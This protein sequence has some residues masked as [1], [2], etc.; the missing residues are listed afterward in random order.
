M[1]HSNDP[2][3]LSLSA[4]WERADVAREGDETALVVRVQASTIATSTSARAPLD[5]AF[6]LDRSGS[7]HGPDKIDLVKDAVIAA[8]HHLADDDR[9]A[10][11]TFDDRVEV[12]HELTP[13]DGQHKRRLERVLRGVEAR[14]STNLS[15]GWLTACQQ[16]AASARSNGTVRL[17]RSILLTDGMA[18]VGITDPHELVTHATELRRRGIDT[19]TIGVG[20]HFDEMLLSGMAEA[21]GGAF[22]YISDPAR[23]QPFFEREIGELMDIVAVRPVLRI[24]FPSAVRGRLVSAFPVDR[25]GKTVIVDLR[26][27]A[28][29]ETIDLVFDITVGDGAHAHDL[30]PMVELEWRHPRTGDRSGMHEELPGLRLVEAQF[31]RSAPRDDEAA[32]IVARARSDRDQR[33]A[34]RLDRMGYF[35]ES[36]AKFMRS[37]DH[38]AAAPPSAKMR[39]EYASAMD[40]AMSPERPL[41]EH[42]RK[43]RI[44]E[45]HARSR[46]RR[47]DDE[48]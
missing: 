46:G 16:L 4:L 6:A 35:H 13:A 28:S 47:R 7:M 27:L 33:E 10:L 48:S 22:E 5:I 44:Q 43:Q 12:L 9:V 8:T 15:G 41:D 11:V 34:V 39:S 23:L 30:S 32:T 36:R 14:G 18:N 19:T 25:Q 1:T 31:A 20:R 21:G 17:Q 45:T 40:L 29:G 38:L 37:A 24:T 26:N 3:H 2:A 42:V